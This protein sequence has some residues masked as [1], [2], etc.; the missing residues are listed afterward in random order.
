MKIRI[1]LILL[2]ILPFVLKGQITTPDIS[3]VKEK[4]NTVFF[5]KGAM[6]V[7]KKDGAVEPVNLYIQGTAK[8]AEGSDIVQKGVT[9]VLGDFVYSNQGWGVVAGAKKEVFSFSTNNTEL[10]SDGIIRFGNKDN[11]SAGLS[12]VYGK[13]DKAG[14]QPKTLI[15]QTSD[16]TLG[17]LI[18]KTKQ[19]IS[20]ESGISKQ[21]NFIHFPKIELAANTYVAI[22]PSAALTVEKLTTQ[23]G[24]LFSV[25]GR[26]Y[27]TDTPISVDG[28]QY[29][30]LILKDVDHQ[31]SSAE[32]SAT[33]QFNPAK[34]LTNYSYHVLDVQLYDKTKYNTDN[35]ININR[36]SAVRFTGVT[37]PFEKLSNSYFLFHTIF[38]PTTIGYNYE[39][40]VN[41]K[42]FI[43]PGEG[44][45]VAM[46]LSDFDHTQI[47]GNW[48]IDREERAAAGFQFSSLFA[49]QKKNFLVDQRR[50]AEETNINAGNWL[51]EKFYE[52]AYWAPETFLTTQNTTV[53][54]K[55]NKN[56]HGKV[57][58][59]NPFMAPFDLAG[60]TTGTNTKA[61]YG[62]TAGSDL[63]SNNVNNKFWIVKESGL[64]YNVY[65]KKNYYELRGWVMSENGATAYLGTPGSMSIAPQQVFALEVGQTN[66][67]EEFY[68]NPA[69]LNHNKS[70]AA[71]SERPLVDELLIQ[72][73]NEDDNREDRTCVVF[74][75]D[76]QMA[77]NDKIDDKKD[78]L[79]F[80]FVGNIT[81]LSEAAVY[82]TAANNQE[83]RTNA[84]P[85]TTKS[86]PLFVS[87]TDTPKRLVLKPYRLETLQSVEGVWL[88]DK[89]TKTITQLQPEMEYPFESTLKSDKASLE[90]R[91]IL[92]FARGD[93]NDKLIETDS[94]ISCSYINS[95]LYIIGLNSN[96]LNS[97][98]EL[99]DLQGRLIAQTKVDN[100]PR[101]QYEKRLD[102]GVYIV[103][104]SG[105]R[106]F[107][108]KFMSTQ[109]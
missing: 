101:M 77:A 104:I 67:T 86:L 35:K 106:N 10:N 8:V 14:S 100:A 52:E 25:E 97:K 11:M 13:A 31:K 85:T 22:N 74:R 76:A 23:V 65:D 55:L 15:G 32:A 45:M 30:H 66:G 108:A 82:T 63:S 29:G 61:D 21:T 20:F 26:P 84:I 12:V 4:T 37:S 43:N 34:A 54:V 68:F 46:E 107:T 42:K 1:L 62:I 109:N 79:R 90:N 38:D 70:I 57:Y 72:V 49:S 83:M 98:V 3:G 59:T 75:P 40:Y 51:T 17:N 58:L 5:N 50:E 53:R 41:P 33:A 103:R 47:E 95:V 48:L 9:L 18:F 105:K 27:K 99:F 88:E 36:G 81:I 60:I 69:K 87:P 56:K 7:A 39:P 93:K 2:L 24:S 71:K 92:H 80:N 44:Y 19:E 78:D 94:Q 64:L 73:I 16:K 28:I 89:L 6:Y 91:F 96:D 102:T